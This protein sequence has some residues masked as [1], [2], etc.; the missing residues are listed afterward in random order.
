ME[1]NL[2]QY[3]QIYLICG[4]VTRQLGWY[5]RWVGQVPGREVVL[6]AQPPTTDS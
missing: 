5:I 1:P 2:E 4:T 3:Q 6:V